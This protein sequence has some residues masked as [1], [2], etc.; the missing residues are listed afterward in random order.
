M[1][2]LNRMK[3][4]GELLPGVVIRRLLNDDGKNN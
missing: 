3:Y 1:F 2:N 4:S